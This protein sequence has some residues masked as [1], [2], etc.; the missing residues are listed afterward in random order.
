MAVSNWTGGKSSGG[1]KSDS[2]HLIQLKIL[3]LSVTIKD[4]SVEICEW[5][6][7]VVGGGGEG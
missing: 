1:G 3:R 4:G 5:W 2:L 6:Q 7:C